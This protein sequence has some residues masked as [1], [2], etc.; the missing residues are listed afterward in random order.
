MGPRSAHQWEKIRHIRSGRQL[1][2]LLG[3]WICYISKNM[4][5]SNL[6]LDRTYH[7]SSI[8]KE[9]SKAK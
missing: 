8:N 4:H 9:I 6:G 3:H 7:L 1:V 2:R 5:L